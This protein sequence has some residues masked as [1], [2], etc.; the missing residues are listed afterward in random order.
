MK[1]ITIL[2]GKGG[3]GKSSITASLAVT[4]FKSK[5]I[6]CA[7][8]DVDASNLALVFGIKEKSYKEWK[9]LSTAQISKFDYSKCDKCR[10]CF[11]SCYF[12][13]IEFIG[14]KPVLKKFSC[15]GC[16][17]CEIVCPNDAI[18]LVNVNNA[19]IGWAETKYGF[20]IISSQLKIG[21]SGSGK[22]VTE[23]K[24]KA[25]DMA[26]KA[27]IMLIDSAAGIGC[28][29]I[30]SV[31][32]SDYCV[33]V[34]EPTPS[35]IFDMK[36]A[37]DVVKHF[38]IPCGIIINKFDL[39]KEYCKN[40]E[41]FASDNNLNILGK[42]PYNKIFSSALVDMTPVVEINKEIKKI[43]FNIANNIL[44]ESF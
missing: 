14:N 6:I 21:E 42:L 3:T 8:C 19:R 4:L 44:K 1:T 10:K 16:G 40:I 35:G 32:G 13:A 15:E 2:S 17:V 20:K 22:I 27:D 41:K 39:N 23:V 11:E 26:D 37:Y 5:K 34:V 30:A 25:K 18:K 24:K 12:E 31:T 29:V 33:L 36:R 9:E 38:K 7:D 28:P 43:F